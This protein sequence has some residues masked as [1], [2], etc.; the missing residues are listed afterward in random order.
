MPHCLGHPSLIPAPCTKSHT[1]LTISGLALPHAS[2]WPHA[3][4]TLAL[5]LL[6]FTGSAS[7]L[8]GLCG[9][10]SWLAK[11][12]SAPETD[13]GATRHPSHWPYRPLRSPC[14]WPKSPLPYHLVA[15]PLFIHVPAAGI[16]GRCILCNKAESS[17]QHFPWDLWPAGLSSFSKHLPAGWGEHFSCNLLP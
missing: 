9:L 15:L 1:F 7:G 10:A 8:L 11:C 12:M 2:I 3:K 14:P 17:K 4:Q 6:A 13:G 5:H 16:G